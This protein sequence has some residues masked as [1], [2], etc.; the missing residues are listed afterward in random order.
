MGGVSRFATALKTLRNEHSLAVFSGDFLMPSDLA[1]FTDGEIMLE[2]YNN[3]H[4][5]M[6][7]IGNHE[8]DLRP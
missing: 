8:F 3:L 2:A 6:G 7:T 5:D 4:L 1:S